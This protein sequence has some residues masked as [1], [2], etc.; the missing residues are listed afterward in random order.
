M[1]SQAIAVF[2]GNGKK[3]HTLLILRPSLFFFVY[4]FPDIGSVG[5][6]V[7]KKKNHKKSRN[8]RPWYPR[9]TLLKSSKWTD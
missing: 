1:F 7:K 4:A 5:R 2:V 3:P 6:F 8:R 9:T